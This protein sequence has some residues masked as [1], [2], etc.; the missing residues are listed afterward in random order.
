MTWVRLVRIQNNSSDTRAPPPHFTWTDK[1]GNDVCLTRKTY[2]GGDICQ[3][4]TDI[5]KCNWI[6]LERL[7]R[8]EIS[9]RIIG[10]GSAFNF[11]IFFQFT[12]QNSKTD[13][14]VFQ[15]HVFFFDLETK[16]F[17]LRYEKH[18]CKYK[19]FFDPT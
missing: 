17:S 10:L 7:I 6:I 12:F 3:Q 18:I 4:I 1:I 11:H 14:L 5:S 19:D 2:I 15:K 16:N 13:A 8:N 9:L